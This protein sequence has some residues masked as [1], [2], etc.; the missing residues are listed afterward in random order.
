MIAGIPKQKGID[1]L[2]TQKGFTLV[3][4]MITVAIVA[5][6]ASIAYPSYQG[7]I[8]RSYR[9]SGQGDLLAFAASMERHFSGAFTYKGAAT[10]GDTGA[11]AVFSAFSPASEPM[12]NRR[13]DLT[14]KSATGTD[15]VL[16]ATP[17]SGSSQEGDGALFYFSDGRKGWDTNNNG[18][19]DTGEFCWKC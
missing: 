15:F 7:V 14:I 18:S 6:I 12:E 2:K 11:P 17:V 3:E 10:S 4:L 13:Y 9:S 16:V 1:K 19:I 5:I 8:K